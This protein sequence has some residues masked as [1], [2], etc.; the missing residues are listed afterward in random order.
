MNAAL[1]EALCRPAARQMTPHR[2]EL[3]AGRANDGST[4]SRFE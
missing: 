1:Q 3:T 2:R 4:I